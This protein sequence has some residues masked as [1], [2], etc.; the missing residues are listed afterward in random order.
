MLEHFLVQLH[1]LVAVDIAEHPHLLVI[2]ENLAVV[3]QEQ[4][5]LNAEADWEQFEAFFLETWVFSEHVHYDLALLA[6]RWPIHD[7]DFLRHLLETI[8]E[9]FVHDATS[10]FNLVCTPMWNWGDDG[11]S[12]SLRLRK[13][14]EIWIHKARHT[15]ILRFRVIVVDFK[16]AITRLQRRFLPF[17][18]FLAALGRWCLSLFDLRYLVWLCR[19]LHLFGFRHLLSFL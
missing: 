10:D 4:T 3:T 14:L 16:T 18:L 11:D 1:L 17:R 5:S 13:R 7:V 2:I 9:G 12:V 19:C 8:M 6:Q 15:E